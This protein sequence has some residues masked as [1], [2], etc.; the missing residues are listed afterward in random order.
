MKQKVIQFE[1]PLT[2]PIKQITREEFDTG[3]YL[4]YGEAKNE[5]K[6]YVSQAIAERILQDFDKLVEY[7]YKRKDDK[8]YQTARIAIMGDDTEYKN[9]P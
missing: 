2:M 4:D 9:I 5:F 8:I 6:K 7:R 3:P 1:V